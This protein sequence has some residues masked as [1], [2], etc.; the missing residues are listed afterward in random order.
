MRN[1]KGQFVKG[2][3]GNPVGRPKTDHAALREELAVHGSKV[4]SVVI[5]A[6]LKGDLQA[7]KMVLDRISPPLK[8]QTAP[9]FLDKSLPEGVSD[10]AR[11]FLEAAA[12]RKLAPDVS[13]QLVSADGAGK[14]CYGKD[15]YRTCN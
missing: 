11:E 14:V 4:A 15:A 6:V 13:A 12:S 7:C 9:I 3:S 1:E 5:K 2:I 8:A 10:I